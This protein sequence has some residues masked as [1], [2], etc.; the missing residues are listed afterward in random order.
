VIAACDSANAS[1]TL[2]PASPIVLDPPRQ[3]HEAE[4]DARGRELRHAM[5]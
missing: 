3:E 1:S 4:H 5:P 2:S